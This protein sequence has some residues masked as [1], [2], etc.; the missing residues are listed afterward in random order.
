MVFSMEKLA[1]KL[2]TFGAKNEEK[3]CEPASHAGPGHKPAQS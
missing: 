1:K 2:A 3:F